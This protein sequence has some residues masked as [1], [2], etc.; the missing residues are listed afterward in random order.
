[1]STLARAQP[2]SRPHEDEYFITFDHLDRR[3]VAIFTTGSLGQQ[4]KPQVVDVVRNTLRNNRVGIS[5]TY[6]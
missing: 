5:R 4:R 6:Q 1:M 2:R 3:R